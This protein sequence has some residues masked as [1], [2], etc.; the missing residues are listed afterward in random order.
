MI[1]FICDLLNGSF[2]QMHLIDRSVFQTVALSPLLSSLKHVD[3]AMV[4]RPGY[5]T[6][7]RLFSCL[8]VSPHM[9]NN[10]I[11]TFTFKFCIS[12]PPSWTDPELYPEGR[13][14]MIITGKFK[15]IKKAKCPKFHG[16]YIFLPPSP[17]R[18]QVIFDFSYHTHCLLPWSL[19]HKATKE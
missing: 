7:L 16:C 9:Q 13:H 10:I 11:S 8:A 14:S 2:I 1:G 12:S 17:L 6:Y 15:K 5:R 4:R 18:S 19:S 3:T